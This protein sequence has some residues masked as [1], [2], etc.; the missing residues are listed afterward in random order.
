[1]ATVE[2]SLGLHER[3]LRVVPHLSARL[4]RD[5]AELLA[6]LAPLRDA[7][8]DRLF[9]VG[10]DPD[11]PGAYPD[12]LSLLREMA[13]LGVL[14]AEIGIGCYPQGHPFIPDDALEAALATRRR[15]RRT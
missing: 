1:M 4:T 12:A 11:E 6:F 13:D 15:S 5:R 9:V 2:L 3:G 10:G 7:G 14:P 8:I